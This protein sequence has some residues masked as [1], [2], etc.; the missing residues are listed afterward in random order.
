M[1]VT[2]LVPKIGYDNASRIAKKALKNGTT[3]REEAIKS[4][5]VN[6]KEFNKLTDPRKMIK[7]R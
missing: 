4:G 3:L 1:L 7:P 2:G 5:L 6:E